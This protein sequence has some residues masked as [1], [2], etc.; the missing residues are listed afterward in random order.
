MV[1]DAAKGI[2]MQTLKLFEVC[3]SKNIPILTCINK[4]DRDSRDP[5]D[6]L[7]EIEKRL[8]LEV[9]PVTWPVGMGREFLGC[10]HLLRHELLLLD[11]S[12][13][14][15]VSQGLTVGLDDPRLE[16][17]LP[18][19]ALK[20]LKTQIEMAQGLCPA[21]SLD[22]YRAGRR[23]AVFFGSA[24]R[25]FG[26]REILRALMEYAPSPQPHNASERTVQ[27][28]E[29][30]ATGFIFKIQANMDPRHRDR[31]AF[32]RV[33]SGRFH[34]G[35]KLFHVRSGKTIVLH[36][37]ALIF[38]RDRDLVEE[39]WPGDII[40]IPNHGTLCVGDTLTEG[41]SLHFHCTPSFAPELM[42]MVRP[43]DPMRAKHLDRALDQ[44][45]EEGVARVFLTRLSTN[46]I[47]GVVG[48]LQFDVLADR[49]R[50][51]YDIPVQFLPIPYSTARWV[52]ADEATLKRFTKEN[53]D[54][55]AIDHSGTMVFLARNTSHLERTQ[56]DW[57]EVN[58]LS[59]YE[60]PVSSR[61]RPLGN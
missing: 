9:S 8:G 11:R 10:Y 43:I 58:L 2:E 41:E 44:L 27:P 56:Q 14:D 50:S 57:P 16:Q 17:R 42:Q 49:I 12:E 21:F 13:S 15:V 1:I 60:A 6:L 40:G 7:S 35:M 31:I 25:S 52:V 37:P 5:F 38:A 19:S 32:L 29:S 4:M 55:I 48:A 54:S 26:V 59:R 33:C 20:I 3:R 24:L 39:A 22:A 36:N 61:H 45:A 18:H 53:E 46:R 47:V 34:K 30:T 51:E 28:D 23:T